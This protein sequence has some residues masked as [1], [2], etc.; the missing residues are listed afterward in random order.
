MDKDVR[1]EGCSNRKGG[2]NRDV[3]YVF[4]LNYHPTEIHHMVVESIIGD[5]SLLS[6]LMLLGTQVYIYDLYEICYL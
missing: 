6:T 3:F 1:A 5:F 2:E 4:W